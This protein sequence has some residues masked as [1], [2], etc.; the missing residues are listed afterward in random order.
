VA[1]IE[2]ARQPPLHAAGRAPPDPVASAAGIYGMN[3]RNMPERY[4]RRG[5][6]YGWGSIILTTLIPLAIFRWRR[7]I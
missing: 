1:E 3:F 7:W 5:H 2:S 4:W 6:A